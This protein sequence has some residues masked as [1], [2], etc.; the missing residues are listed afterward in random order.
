M[1]DRDPSACRPPVLDLQ[2]TDTASVAP[3]PSLRSTWRHVTHVRSP[4]IRHIDCNERVL[5]LLPG[6]LVCFL[7]VRSLAKDRARTAR[8]RPP[9]ERWQDKR[10][11]VRGG[12]AAE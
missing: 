1:S 12:R 11:E 6:C 5:N 7:S 3:A 2:S 8:S 10:R 4:K 9:T